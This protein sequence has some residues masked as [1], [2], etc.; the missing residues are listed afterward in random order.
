MRRQ[1]PRRRR[2]LRR[3][4]SARSAATRLDAGKLDDGNEVTST[5]APTAAP[6]L[7]AAMGPAPGPAPEQ[8]GYEAR[9]DGNEVD[10]DGCTPTAAARCGDGRLDRNEQCD[11]GNR[12]NFDAC[13]NACERRCGDGII[14]EDSMRTTR[15]LK[16]G[17]QRQRPR[18]AHQGRARARCGD[19]IVRRDI[20]NFAGGWEECDDGNIVQDDGCT[21]LPATH[22]RRRRLHLGPDQLPR[23]PLQRHERRLGRLRLPQGQQRGVS[24][25]FRVRRLGSSLHGASP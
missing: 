7:A 14:R 23:L 6:W 10:G 9:D 25:R 8:D 24:S 12:T 22:R 13:T 18:R 5:P 3:R 19:G 4:L 20:T 16:P 17:T 15:A 11:D 21:R 1:Q 2:R